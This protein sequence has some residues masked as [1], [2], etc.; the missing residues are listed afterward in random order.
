MAIVPADILFRLAGGAG[1]SDPNASLGGVMST[2][3]VIVDATVEN[4]FDNVTGAESTPG[5]TEYRSLYLLNNHGSLTFQSVVLWISTETTSADS[6][7][8]LAL[9]GEGLNATM[10]TI[11]DESTAPIGESFTHPTTEGGGLSMGNIPFGQRFGLW[12]ER[13]ISAAA[14]AAAADAGIIT[15][16][17]DT[18][19]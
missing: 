19:A 15:F 3:T 2:S 12:I 4:L 11:A 1:N 9:A 17:G 5:D 16:K 6:L 8:N 14:A 7:M 10:E 13:I 18:A